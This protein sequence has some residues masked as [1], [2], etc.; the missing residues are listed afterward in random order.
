MFDSISLTKKVYMHDDQVQFIQ[1]D[2]SI[3]NHT[4]VKNLVQVHEQIK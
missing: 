2:W 4:Q 3:V 1:K